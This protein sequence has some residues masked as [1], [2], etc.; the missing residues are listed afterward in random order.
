MPE[1]PEVETIK[2]QLGKKIIGKS[3]QGKKIAAVRRRA[4]IL[5]IDFADGSSLIF[6][7]KMTGQ[8]IFNGKPSPYTRKVFIFDDNSKMIF[9]DARKFGWWKQVKTAKEIE[10]QF[11]PECLE[12]DFK[13]FKTGLKKHGRSKIKT[14]L[15][16]QKVIAGIGN[17]YSD[18]ILFAAKIH[19]LRLVSGLNEREMGR[20]FNQMK[21]ILLRAVEDKGSSVEYYLDACGEK[22]SYAKKHK[23]YQKEKQKC[24]RCSKRI[25][26]I[27]IGGRTARFCPGCQAI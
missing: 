17:I 4:K 12:I 21:R 15:M 23:V 11:G 2:R 20:I 13:S 3:L 10:K 16:D 18:E 25:E 1:L 14:L 8:L 26:K 5:I 24:P 27:K 19:P 6:H 7:L 22:G 9:N